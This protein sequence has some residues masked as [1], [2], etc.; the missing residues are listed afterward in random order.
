MYQFLDAT[1]Q[2]AGVVIFMT[3]PE[4]IIQL[5]TKDPLEYRI[6]HEVQI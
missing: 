5:D 1:L 6:H 2:A 4:K 3:K